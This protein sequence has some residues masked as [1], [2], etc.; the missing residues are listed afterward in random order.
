V[1]PYFLFRKL[2]VNLIKSKI[3]DVIRNDCL[4][5][6]ETEITKEEYF[7]R[8]FKPIH[9]RSQNINIFNSLIAPPKIIINHNLMY[10][11]LQSKI[12]KF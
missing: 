8:K 9:S 10:S 4:V 3:K 1:L 11:D 7:N 2:V 6:N 5:F 12:N